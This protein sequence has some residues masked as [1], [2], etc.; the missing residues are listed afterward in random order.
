MK[1]LLFGKNGQVGWELNR[2]LQPLG[3]IIALG[4]EEADFSKPESLRKIVRDVQPDVI[5]NAAAFTAVDKAESE[6]DLATIINGVAPGVLADEARQINALLVHYST[7]YVFDGAKSEPYIE[8]DGPNP[9]NAYGRSKLAGEEAIHAAGCHY[10][11][12]R[13]AW[14]FSVHGYNFIKTILRVAREREIINVVADQHG[15]PTSAELIADVTARVISGPRSQTLPCGIYHLT[16]AGETTWYSLACY[17]VSRALVNGTSLTLQPQQIHAITAEEYPLPAKRPNNSR[18][19]TANLSNAL[20]LHF[21]D[22]QI[23]VDRVV[24]LLTQVDDCA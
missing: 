14:V 13:T 9:V 3:E 2:S 15:A 20:D 23:H 1:I 4:R 6:E 16:A 21:P 5:I 17:V 12:F 11:I 19:N 24:D 10:L 18:M 8:S 7:D 22:W